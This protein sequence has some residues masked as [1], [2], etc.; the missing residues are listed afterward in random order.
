MDPRDWIGLAADIIAIGTLLFTAA[1]F[2]QA[3]RKLALAL[4]TIQMRGG[5]A[6]VALAIGLG[7]DIHKAVEIYLQERGMSMPVYNYTKAGVV[8]SSQFHSVLRD[9][10]EIKQRITS[11]GVKEVHLFYMGPVTLSV[12]LGAVLDNWAPV[13]VYKYANGRYEPEF[14]LQKETVLGL[15][16]QAVDSGIDMIT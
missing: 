12:G 2:W 4:K 5:E 11:A 3:R 14:V 7:Q 9:I 10:L 8:P 15:L 16:D 1:V 13:I 6:P